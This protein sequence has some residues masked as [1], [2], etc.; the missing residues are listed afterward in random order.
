MQLATDP[1]KISRRSM[2]AAQTKEKAMEVDREQAIRERAYA[3]WERDG[4]PDGKALEY[5]LH[6]ELEISEM[7]N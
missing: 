6:A 1:C 3:L 7:A 2:M 4:C 5:W